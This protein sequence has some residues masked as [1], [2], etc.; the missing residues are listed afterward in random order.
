MGCSGKMD[1]LRMFDYKLELQ[2]HIAWIKFIVEIILSPLL[3]LLHE[4]VYIL[5]ELREFAFFY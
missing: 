5:N 1:H 2:N 3:N 4:P